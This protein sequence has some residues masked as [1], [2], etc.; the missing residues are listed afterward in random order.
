MCNKLSLE[1]ILSLRCLY[2]YDERIP[3]L[4][5]SL[6]MVTDWAENEVIQGN[7][8]EPLFIL[9]SLGLDSKIDPNEAQ[10]YLDR[11]LVENNIKRPTLDYSCLI[12]FK[13]FVGRIAC[14]KSLEEISELMSEVLFRWYDFENRYFNNIYQYLTHIYYQYFDYYIDSYCID[15]E[16]QLSETERYNIVKSLAERFYKLLNNVDMLTILSK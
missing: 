8:S 15:S 2:A 5:L 11:Y 1:E 10:L 12:F 7:Q 16:Q 4:F 14:S 3:K 9:A 13:I 6:A